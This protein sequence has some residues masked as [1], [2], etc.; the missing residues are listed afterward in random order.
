[1]CKECR[2]GYDI[3]QE[4]IMYLQVWYLSYIKN[5]VSNK[6]LNIELDLSAASKTAA[7]IVAA[8]KIKKSCCILAA[9][10]RAAAT[11]MPA[12]QTLY[13]LFDSNAILSVYK[14]F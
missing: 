2:Y 8:L 1:M 12:A 3:W 14:Y 13:T 5:H 7:R 9:D 10:K 6:Q 4:V 11:G